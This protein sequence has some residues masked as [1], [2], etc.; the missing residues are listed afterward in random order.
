MLLQFKHFRP[1]GPCL[2]YHLSH[3]HRNIIKYK[4]IFYQLGD[5]SVIK[6]RALAGSVTAKIMS[7]ST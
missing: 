7:F 1:T 6:T 4:P 5:L 2:T 3:T